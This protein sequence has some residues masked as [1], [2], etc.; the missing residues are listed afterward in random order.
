MIDFSKLNNTND[1]KQTELDPRKIFENL[2]NLKDIPNDLWQGQGKTLEEW[3]A[4]RNKQDILISLNTGAGKTIVGL[5][6]AQSLI[7]AENSS[8][9]YIC[10]TNDLVKQTEAEAKK[11]GIDCTT[12]I[13]GAFSNDLF[14]TGKSFCITTYAT[15]FNGHS[16]F[17]R[18]FIPEAI[19]FD[20]AHVAESILRDSFTINIKKQ[21]HE[22][23]FGE[24]VN[25]FKSHFQELGI[26]EKFND[27]LKPNNHNMVMV[28]PREL[29]KQRMQLLAI[30]KTHNVANDSS[31]TFAFQHLK[32]KLDVCVAI[33]AHETFEL[34]LP[35][36][37]SLAL[38]IFNLQKKR[39]YLSATLQ[40]QVEFIRAFGRKPTHT[41]RPDNDAGNGERL[42]IT[43]IAPYSIF[44]ALYVNKV[45][46]THKIVVAVSSYNEAKKWHSVSNPPTRELFTETLNKFRNASKGGFILVSRVDGID[47]PHDQCRIMLIEGLPSGASLLEKYQWHFLGMLNTQNIR[48]ANRLTQLFGRINRGRSDYG[49]FFIAGKELNIWLKDDRNIAL[50]P[51]LLQKQLSLGLKARKELPLNDSDKISDAIEKIF[52]RDDGWLNYYSRQI[53]S[54]SDKQ[55]KNNE[56]IEKAALAEAQYAKHMWKNE[57]CK[58]RKALEESIDEFANADTPLGGWHGVWL[59]ASFDFEGDTV[60]A[61]TAYY[62]A[63]LRL[64]SNIT[65]PKSSHNSQTS[66]TTACNAFCKSLL[67]YFNYQRGLQQLPKKIKR[68]KEDLEKIGKTTTSTN[69]YEEAVRRLGEFL[70]FQSTR[71]D[72]D[73]HVGP[74]VIWVDEHN[75]SLISFEL[76]TDKQG[77]AQYNKEDIGQ[78]LNHLEWVNAQYNNYQHLSLLYVGPDWNVSVQANPSSKMGLCTIR[79]I[80]EL[81]DEVIALI[82]DISSSA[83]SKIE[84]VISQKSTEEKW[85]LQSLLQKLWVRNMQSSSGNT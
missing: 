3:Y 49:V 50:L 46:T 33:F 44:S 65:L 32:D 76:K 15:L 48:I 53:A 18:N 5:L 8:V 12:R 23:M 47:L 6:I 71:P 80:E 60:S 31:L 68:L 58:A 59:G 38:D 62:T 29:K 77:K 20:D 40:S 41:I 9:L 78:G 63:E 52:D 69:Q 74:D 7:N 16:V 75:K 55:I 54:V 19:I 73:K 79:V 13:S 57:Y 37:P 45:S 61:E 64:G 36:L 2:P 11:V 27:S 84:E 21:Q 67:S 81:K 24:I 85:Q 14:E 72:N 28:T 51:I 70:G 83:S 35:F 43:D 42:I 1:D 56:I 17:Q 25:L 82:N 4:N 26:E 39:I 22:K 10:S 34:T 30:F 66:Q